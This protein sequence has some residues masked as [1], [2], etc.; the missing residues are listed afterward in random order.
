[1]QSKNSYGSHLHLECNHSCKTFPIF[2]QKRPIFGPKLSIYDKHVRACRIP[3]YLSPRHASNR[4]QGKEKVDSIDFECLRKK[5][6]AHMQKHNNQ[7]TS[8]TSTNTP[9]EKQKHKGGAKS[10]SALA[11]EERHKKRSRVPHS[12]EKKNEHK[13]RWRPGRK[14]TGTRTQHENL[15]V[16]TNCALLSNTDRVCVG[17]MVKES[18]CV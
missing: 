9:K 13:M 15:L 5:E 17:K 12:L 7:T 6:R 3:W 8:A 11:W 14:T 10:L 2:L 4:F 18:A 16:N 1:M